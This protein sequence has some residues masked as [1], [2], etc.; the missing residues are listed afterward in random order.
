M[1]CQKGP[2]RVFLNGDTTDAQIGI[3]SLH[4][5][6]MT[7]ADCRLQTADC[8]LQT[9]DC[10]PQTADHRSTA[11]CRPQIADCK[12][13]DTKNRPNKGDTIKNIT[14]YESEKVAKLASFPRCCWLFFTDATLY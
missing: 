3:M 8:R 12:L 11:D 13:K 6:C 2:K 1:F 10:R 9:A 14:S 4:V 7:F 5:R